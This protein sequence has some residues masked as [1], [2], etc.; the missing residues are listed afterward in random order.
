MGGDESAS[1]LGGLALVGCVRAD[2]RYAAVPYAS[3]FYAGLDKQVNSSLI[4]RKARQLGQPGDTG[5]L[6]QRG[7]LSRQGDAIEPGAV[8]TIRRI[9]LATRTAPLHRGR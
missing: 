9:L 4:D 2:R 5:L 6:A 1:G 8:F 3:R 7:E